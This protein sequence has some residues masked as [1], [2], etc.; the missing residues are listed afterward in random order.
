MAK[1]VTTGNP[2]I[3]KFLILLESQQGDAT[4]ALIEKI[5][6]GPGVYVFG[7]FL[8]HENVTALRNSKS[9]KQQLWYNALEL[10]AYGTYDDYDPKGKHPELK[11]K[12]LNKLKKLSIVTEAE[13]S[14]TKILYYKDLI[15]KFKLS[16][17]RE[18]ED[19]IIDCIYEGLLK[20]KL[21]QKRQR[22][23]IEYSKGRDI[24]KKN[25]T[26]MKNRLISWLNNTDNLVK[27][28]DDRVKQANDLTNK[29]ERVYK[30]T[31]DTIARVTD[32]LIA[33]AAQDKIQNGN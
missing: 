8:Q 17:V 21:D 32:E 27:T 11:E 31:Q 33:A 6:E 13:L 10:F 14:T 1:Q 2:H 22:L 26:A 3:D 25:I 12:Q 4:A 5:L 16:N 30:N 29:R 7:T 15:E 9:K 20:G 28:L 19:F 23:E 18:L 24:S